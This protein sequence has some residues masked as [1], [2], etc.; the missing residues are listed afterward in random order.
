MTGQHPFRPTDADRLAC[1]TC[2]TERHPT[3]H[4]GPMDDI[5]NHAAGHDG[6][7]ARALDLWTCARCS[8]EARDG[9]NLDAYELTSGR[10]VYIIA[11]SYDT[12]EV[13]AYC[14]PCI[15]DMAT[16]SRAIAYVV[17]RDDTAHCISCDYE[18]ADAL[19]GERHGRGARAEIAR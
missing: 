14:G 9:I 19:I 2:G 6:L 13:T 10:A 12:A 11:N 7:R 3:K 15:A 18:T 5:A 17:G 16:P 8:A 1:A 4:A